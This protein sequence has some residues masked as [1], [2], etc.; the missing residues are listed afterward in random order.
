MD[1][2]SL[3]VE[4]LVSGAAAAAQEAVGDAYRTL[5]ALVRR[6]F[7]QSSRPD[8]ILDHVGRLPAA[9]EGDLKEALADVG[10]GADPDIM[11]AA[12]HVLLLIYPDAVAAGKF[13]VNTTGNVYGQVVGDRTS[14]AM[15]FGDSS[16]HE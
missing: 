1:P 5:R 13:N 15:T 4:A 16:E 11:A 12:Q 7:D 8:S 10:A 3:I 9:V 2:V 14:V 6:R